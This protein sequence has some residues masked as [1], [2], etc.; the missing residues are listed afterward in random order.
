MSLSNMPPTVTDA[1]P[2]PVAN[3]ASTSRRARSASSP[4]AADANA[5]P[6]P[7]SRGSCFPTG[8]AAPATPES[9]PDADG[10]SRPISRHMLLNSRGS[11]KPESVKSPELGSATAEG[12]RSIARSTPCGVLPDGS[13][14]TCVPAGTPLKSF[15]GVGSPKRSDPARS[16]PKIEPCCAAFWNPNPGAT[17]AAPPA[18]ITPWERNA[19]LIPA[20]TGSWQNESCATCISSAA[21]L[22]G[23]R[24][25]GGVPARRPSRRPPG[26]PTTESWCTGGG[27]GAR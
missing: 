22:R 27:G 5:S 14:F 19:P 3:S 11:A 6:S 9:R 12:G 15:A 17:F 21:R 4:G 16:A 8:A 24:F 13:A 2:A 7:A 25:S 23:E 20:L 18:N 10:S 1:S 26:P